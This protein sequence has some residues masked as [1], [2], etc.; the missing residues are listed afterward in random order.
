MRKFHIL[1]GSDGRTVVEVDGVI[2]WGR[3]FEHA[4]RRVDQTTLPN[5]KQVS[6]VFLGIN[7]RFSSEGP[8]LLFETMVFA[9]GGSIDVDCVRTSTWDEAQ[10]M[11]DELVQKHLKPD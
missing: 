10:A 5:G 1:G 2:E 3:W 9:P 7:H 11:H 8:P 6:T 4:D